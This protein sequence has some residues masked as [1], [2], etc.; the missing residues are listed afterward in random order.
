[1]HQNRLLALAEAVAHETDVD[2]ANAETDAEDGAAREAVRQ[3]RLIASLGQAS[4]KRLLKW[5]P[6]EIRREVGRGTF[7]KV[8]RAWDPRLRREVALK[9]L[10]DEADA[11]SDVIHEARMLAEV[12]HE[13]IVPVYGADVHDGRVGIWMKFI[14]GKTMREILL[15]QG[16]FGA[17]EAAQIGQDLCRALAAVHR[18]GLVHR[19]VKAQ[20]VMRE[21]G[22]QIVLMDFG[23]GDT[24]EAAREA[25]IKGSPAYLAPEVVGGAPAT[26]QSDIYSLGVL[27]FHLV[28]GE[29]P[30]TAASW[31]ELRARHAQGQRTSLRDARP[32][33]PAWF[34]GAVD[35]ALQADPAERPATAGAM[36]ALLG[37]RSE[38]APP[39]QKDPMPG[40]RLF[41]ALGGSAAMAV[42][43][44]GIWQLAI[45]PPESDVQ[46]IVEQ[47]L[48]IRMVTPR[49]ADDLLLAR[50]D[51]FLQGL[52]RHLRRDVGVRVPEKETLARLQDLP[53]LQ[54]AGATNTAG[55]LTLTIDTPEAST[56]TPRQ[57]VIGAMLSVAA[58]DGAVM[59]SE[60]YTGPI[61]DVSRLSAD[62]AEDI[63]R[64]L[65]HVPAAP[66]AQPQSVPREHA[67]GRFF[68]AKLT[69]ADLRRA[70]DY[71]KQAIR[72]RPD[73][74][75]AHAGLSE[76]VVLLHGNHG[77]Y[78]TT[79]ALTLATD[80]AR[81]AID[82]DSK[83]AGGY[84][85]LGWAAFYLGWDW[86]AAEAA[87]KQAVA[88][89]PTDGVAHHL[90]AD[91]LSAMRRPAEALAQEEMALKVDPASLRFNRGV[92]WIHFFAGDYAAS[93]KALEYTL[94][95][96]SGYQHARTLLA[97]AYA[98]SGRHDEALAEIQK[99][100]AADSGTGNQEILGQ[101]HA[102]A[103]RRADAE[104][105]VASLTAQPAVTGSY[106]RPY[107]LA[108]IW[109]ALGDRAK[110]LDALERAFR[111]HDSTLVNL[112]AD[113]RLRHLRTEPRFMALCDRLRN[114]G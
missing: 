70:V 100:L 25:S 95:L 53:N 38:V 23:A 21:V 11:K 41:A 10:N 33:I 65:G 77:S 113:P 66:T 48:A 34:I 103:G 111:E 31:A 2:W 102:L 43:A 69:E 45:S 40:R 51:E 12:E 39:A 36:E 58:D 59:L 75:P 47:G 89:D 35:R 73:F 1:M 60:S 55:V 87:F 82:L 105:V 106:V 81:R 61:D 101:V 96:D 17:N 6:F 74:A 88:G 108:L 50:S 37:R 76:A 68:A 80:S 91:Y 112:G 8:Y 99:V 32:D 93:V 28:S 42:A 98:Q 18:R 27:L 3:L 86:A 26:A 104:R 52:T 19:D 79:E 72:E 13:N 84:T 90:Y 22:G 44:L 14:T 107:F 5:G 64:R 49:S 62:A 46:R 29:L 30:V 85:A 67:L 56:S 54:F 109:S 114:C 83:F 15:D 63:G 24:I 9:L 94:S 16:P 57:I 20:N 7:G 92:G 97:R 78:T 4:R 110:T 71:Y